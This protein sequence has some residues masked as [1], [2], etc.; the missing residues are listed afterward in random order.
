[1]AAYAAVDLYV[2]ILANQ[3]QIP[4]ILASKQAKSRSLLSQ[5][6]FEAK[7]SPAEK[8]QLLSRETDGGDKNLCCN[9]ST[10]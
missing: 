10:T 7:I 3:E 9:T 8:Q 4:T 2:A 1:L 6:H 5:R